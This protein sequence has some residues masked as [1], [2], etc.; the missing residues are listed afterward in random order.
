MT[1]WQLLALG[2][3]VLLLGVGV[4]AVVFRLQ[5]AQQRPPWGDEPDDGVI[6]MV[7]E[8]TAGT[9]YVPAT[10]QLPPPEDSAPVARRNRLGL[11]L[12]LLIALLAWPA[13]TLFNSWQARNDPNR[14]VVLIAPFRD[15]GAGESGRA[16]AAELARE[17]NAVTDRPITAE[18][19]ATAPAD[20]A[21]ALQT[22]TASS[23]DLLIWGD[24]A[25]GTMLDSES[26]RPLLFYR[27]S[28]TFA[29]AAWDGYYG[30][31]APPPVSALSDRPINGRAVLPSLVGSLAAYA[32]GDIDQA[33]TGLGRL[34]EAYPLRP[35][36]PRSV[37]A[38]VLWARSQHSAAVDEYRRALSGATAEQPYLAN[39]LGAVL[40][41]ARDPQAEATLQQAAGLPGAETVAPLQTNL[42]IAAIQRGDTAAALGYLAR[43]P[44][45]GQR[46]LVVLLTEAA[47]RRANAEYD[48]AEALLDE[49]NR[50]ISTEAGVAPAQHYQLIRRRLDDAVQE[51]R[52]LLD[53]AKLVPG[54]GPL[55]WRFAASQPLDP[56]VVTPLA[57]RFTTVA[58]HST[59]LIREWR[60][61]STAA[62]AAG[63]PIGGSV[64]GGQ[65]SR[66]EG[67]RDRQR[68]IEAVL[69]SE[70]G[71]AD[72]SAR[73]GLFVQIR[74]ALFG[75][76]SAA[77]RAAVI[78]RD[79]VERDPGNA[80]LHIALGNALRLL[81]RAGDADA[82]FT[83]AREINPRQP[84]AFFGQA[85][86]AL[87]GSRTAE[88]KDRLR[89]AIA[90]DASY[91]PA[92]QE[93]ARLEREAG[94]SLA[95]LEQERWLAASRPGFESDL[96]LAVTLRQLG[97]AYY[98]EAEQILLRWQNSQREALVELGRLYRSAGRA[99]EAEQKLAAA[100]AQSPPSADASLEYG[101]LLAESGRP[102]EAEAQFQQALGAD[103]TLVAARLG[104]ARLY[105]GPLDRPAD[106]ARQYEA[107]LDSNFDDPGQLVQAGD[108]M[109]Q[110]GQPR[111]AYRAY[112]RARQANENDPLLYH[113]L[114]QA[115]LALDRVEQ[116]RGEEQQAIDRSGGQLAAAVAGM[117]E[118]TRQAG[119]LDGARQLFEQALGVEPNLPEAF[120]GLGRTSADAGNWS[121]A[122]GYFQSAVAARPGDALSHFWVAEALVRQPAPAYAAAIA[123]YNASLQARPDFPEAVFGIAQSYK[124]L[125]D[126]EA[127]RKQI[128]QAIKLRP[129][130]G[131]ALLFRG[132]LAEEE[133][134]AQ[135][136]YDDY[137]AAIS[138]NGKLA[139][140]YYRRA[141]I[142]VQ[143]ERY[144]N[145]RSDLQRALAIQDNFPEAH[146]WLGRSF[147]IDGDYAAAL[148]E[149]DRALEL[150]YADAQAYR[151][152][153]QQ[154]VDA[155]SG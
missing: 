44:Q 99:A 71:R 144:S 138:G 2:L 89:E 60:E 73:R 122:L 14:F 105:A 50:R 104:L 8:G 1:T 34:L 65:A 11:L 155:A 26:L 36:L 84:E 114:A 145:A 129:A 107:V 31:F 118:I 93:L 24:V 95:A 19:L 25:P 134:N 127:A 103:S 75:D 37:R 91:F 53:V 86:L 6:E 32:Q 35:A 147:F 151:D 142:E 81:D 30:R 55:T 41:D 111:E 63:A 78:L 68:T 97:P 22:L 15:G 62:D 28:G 108:A 7:P 76:G 98:Y 92:R 143:R 140:P 58:D 128:A 52:A 33:F 59:A 153:A 9:S 121:V 149:F 3:I 82:S 38:S 101:T 46:P 10:R 109:L 135:G 110:Y 80:D 4:A 57:R 79:L 88:A 139:E 90:A 133:G 43:L 141:L 112:D 123:E 45:G 87:D 74:D 48:A 56:A 21:A 16:V 146:Y 54:S 85:R 13:V 27:P 117:G 100:A 152:Q 17:L 115:S 130:Y 18:A 40:L 72:P 42:A 132:K 39:D 131:E 113:K 67:V 47:A 150:G 51:Q 102:Q 125:G 94:N 70:Q 148:R 126:R 124:A 106:A 61:L 77:A 96:A 66:L 23:A 29:P 137:G 119:D 69:L 120:I 83:T 49:A 5:R 154:R 136:A 64:A 12:L 20:E 116:A